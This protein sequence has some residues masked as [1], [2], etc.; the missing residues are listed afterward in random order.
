VL[1][2][3]EKLKKTE[4]IDFSKAEYRK[5]NSTLSAQVENGSYYEG[6]IFNNRKHGYGR[7]IESTERIYTGFFHEGNKC[8]QGT[9]IYDGDVIYVGNWLD[10]TFHG[11]GKHTNYDN[12]HVYEGTFSF[13]LRE[14]SKGSS[15]KKQ[16]S[17]DHYATLTMGHF[18]GTY[19][20]EFAD[21]KRHG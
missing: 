21:D 4:P 19:V 18:E 9:L 2:L 12:M 6:Y 8:G 5:D 17:T 7:L 10:D 14:T 1:D 15:S 20:G 13:G 3:K 11:K 16:N